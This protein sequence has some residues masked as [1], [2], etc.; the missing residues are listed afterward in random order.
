ML[1]QIG[2][3]ALNFSRYYLME[4][5]VRMQMSHAVGFWVAQIVRTAQMILWWIHSSRTLLRARSAQARLSSE[6]N[7]IFLVV[8]TWLPRVTSCS[9][10][11]HVRHVWEKTAS[12]QVIQMFSRVYVW[13][14][15]LVIF[16]RGFQA[17]PG[18]LPLHAGGDVEVKSTWI[19]WCIVMISVNQ[20]MCRCFYCCT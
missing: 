4:V 10:L 14:C 15:F 8:R 2:I 16:P 1:E 3:W 9:V 12:S 18:P 7:W 20:F 6:P 5:H 19:Q 11:L 17:L 13:I